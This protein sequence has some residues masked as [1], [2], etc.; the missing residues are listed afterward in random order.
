M[1]SFKLFLVALFMLGS[2]VLSAADSVPHE[3]S[4]QWGPHKLTISEIRANTYGVFVYGV[5]P[6][7]VEHFL[8]LD[9]A[10]KFAKE[11]V[12]MLYTA[13]ASNGVI[14]GTF[15][16]SIEYPNVA[17]MVDIRMTK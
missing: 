10:A 13:Y 1:K 7:N 4:D 2:T 9:S 3:Y 15:D 16:K 17:L 11:M 12:S 8:V 5:T 14:Y 6:D